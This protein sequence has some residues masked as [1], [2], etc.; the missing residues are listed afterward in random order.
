MTN[1]ST[2]DF[3]VHTPGELAAAG[4]PLSARWNAEPATRYDLEGQ[5]IGGIVESVSQRK[6]A[7]QARPDLRSYHMRELGCVGGFPLEDWRALLSEW[8]DTPLDR[9]AV[10]SWS[11]SEDGQGDPDPRRPTLVGT[12]V[13]VKWMTEELYDW[14][15][16]VPPPDL[17]CIAPIIT[18]DEADLLPW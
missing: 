16:A 10:S 6:S 11:S 18:N 3:L 13:I 4:V 9:Q 12:V 15:R 7:V 5:L 17:I 1:E 2:Q 14:V 8:E